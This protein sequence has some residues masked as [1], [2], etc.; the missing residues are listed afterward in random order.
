[1]EIVVHVVTL[2]E[3]SWKKGEFFS[4]DFQP[5]LCSERRC[6]R[7]QIFSYELNFPV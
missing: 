3:A 1:M 4:A 5:F 2:E 6:R 7:K